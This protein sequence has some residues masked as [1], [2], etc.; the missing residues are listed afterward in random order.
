MTAPVARPW[1][2]TADGVLLTVR[3]TP[4]GGKDA[5]DRIEHAADGR[6]VL[7]VRVAAPPSDGEANAALIRLLAK[8]L[9][10]P[11]RAVSLTA[12]HTARTKQLKIAGSAIALAPALERICSTG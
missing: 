5:I 1:Q 8:L 2:V 4:R 10:V 12:G 3:L 9:R 11:A 6:P 7:R